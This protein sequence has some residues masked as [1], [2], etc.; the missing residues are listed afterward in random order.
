MQDGRR[1]D[2]RFSKASAVPAVLSLPY[3]MNGPLLA[4]RFVREVAAGWALDG[5]TSPLCL[6]A[7]EL[8]TNAI[9][10]GAAP[11]EL[12]LHRRDGEVTIEVTDGDPRVTTYGFA[13]EPAPLPAEGVS[14]SSRRWPTAGAHGTREPVRQ[15]GLPCAQRTQNCCTGVA[16]RLRTCERGG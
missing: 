4:R 12:M 6:I 14:T 9:I 13:P 10:H 7:S 3:D 2:A 15:S 16:P 11:T 1:G 8:V 5:A